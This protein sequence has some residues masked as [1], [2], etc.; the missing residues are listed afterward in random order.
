MVKIRDV[1]ALAGVSTATVSRA[2]SQPDKVSEKTRERVMKAIKELNYQPNNLAR[3]LRTARSHSI[4]VIVPGLTNDFF[5]SVLL[6]ID[7]AA[8]DSKYSILLADTRDEEQLEDRFFQ[9]VQTRGADGIIHLAPNP[10]RN[11]D[12]RIKG[13]PIVYACGCSKTPAPSVRIDNISAAE[14]IVRHLAQSG[15]TEIA[16]IAGPKGNAHTEDRLVGYHNELDRHGFKFNSQYLEYGDFRI[17][18][19]VSLTKKLLDLEKPPTAIFCQNDEMALG[20]ISAAMERKLN[21]PDDL[22]VAG[23]DDIHFSAHLFPSLT[24]IAQPAEQMGRE[25]FKALVAAI[26]NPL[27]ET[28]EVVLPYKFIRRGS[29][30]TSN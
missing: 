12:D 14:T 13:V 10:L 4:L 23:F 1:S 17:N 30:Q 18:S 9:M 22:A 21:V 27:A 5:S 3:N 8:K 20:A 11:Q 6:G 7:E 24:T 26:E 15:H 25:A 19:G 2:I 16:C 29:T 28:E